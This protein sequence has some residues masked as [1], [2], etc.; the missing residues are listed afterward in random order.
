[1][2]GSG[3]SPRAGEEGERVQASALSLSQRQE[4]TGVPAGRQAGREGDAL[5]L[6]LL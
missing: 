3:P 2:V 1:M 6:S 4:L 5:L